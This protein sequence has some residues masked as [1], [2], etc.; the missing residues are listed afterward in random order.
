[1]RCGT[2]LKKGPVRRLALLFVG[3]VAGEGPWA[4]HDDAGDRCRSVL[5]ITRH[6]Q[7]DADLPEQDPDVGHLGVVPP[8]QRL[9]KGG[10]NHRLADVLTVAV[11]G[12][13]AGPSWLV[14]PDWSPERPLG[15]RAVMLDP[16]A[17]SST[18]R[19]VNRTPGSARRECEAARP[20]AFSLSSTVRAHPSERPRRLPSPGAAPGS[21]IG[22]Q[23]LRCAG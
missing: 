17:P 18:Q 20:G 8:G 5:R 23:S 6:E 19:P 14:E 11:P 2:R 22:G 15:E 13:S 3:A 9:P 7:A 1:M 10:S 12:P 4:E 21:A 16:T